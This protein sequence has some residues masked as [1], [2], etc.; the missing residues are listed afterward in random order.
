MSKATTHHAQE[1]LD[2]AERR[3]TKRIIDFR[4]IGVHIEP[5]IPLEKMPAVDQITR[6]RMLATKHRRP[7]GHPRHR[8]SHGRTYSSV[9]GS[10]GG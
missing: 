4:N 10:A 7:I 5:N 9:L 3:R 6:L 2:R 1:D 8:S